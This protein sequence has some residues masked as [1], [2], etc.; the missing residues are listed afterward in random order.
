MRRRKRD[1]LDELLPVYVS[2]PALL[3]VIMSK[4][5][6]TELNN[7]PFLIATALGTTIAFVLAMVI[8]RI[9]PS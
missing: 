4:T 6:F 8:G 3:F 7:P 9:M 1:T 5:P 2:L